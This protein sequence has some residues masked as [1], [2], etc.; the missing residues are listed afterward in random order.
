MESED[1]K[2]IIFARAITEIDGLSAIGK[3]SEIWK[4]FASYFEEKGD[5]LNTNIIF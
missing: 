5:L 3:F 1:E 2:P 4:G